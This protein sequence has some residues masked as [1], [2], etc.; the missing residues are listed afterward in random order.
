[1]SGGSF[2][3]VCFNAEENPFNALPDLQ[4]MEIWLRSENK[5]L[6]AGEILKYIL[7]IETAKHRLDTV[8]KFY[9]DLLYSIEWAC[10]ADYSIDAVDLQM[11][12][13]L[14]IKK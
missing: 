11:D 6:A 4:D 7:M 9:K 3:Y 12:K 8:Y 13:L 10:S 14:D 2:N 1:M 5:Q